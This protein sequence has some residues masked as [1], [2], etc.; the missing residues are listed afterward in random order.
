MNE[1]LGQTSGDE[2]NLTHNQEIE[3]ATTPARAGFVQLAPGTTSKS[4]VIKIL[5]G[6]LLVALLAVGA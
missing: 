5:I 3:D 4:T 6:I 2:T 1:N